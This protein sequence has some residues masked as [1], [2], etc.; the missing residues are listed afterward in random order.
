MNDLVA[1]LHTRRRATSRR[2][3]LALSW[4]ALIFFSSNP[5]IEL[6]SVEMRIKF[7]LGPGV[8]IPQY[9]RW[10]IANNLVAMRG[11]KRGTKTD[12]FYRAGP[13]LLEELGSEL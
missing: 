2:S 6:S 4:R 9:I 10:L 11:V 12:N 8:S 13:A 5:D 1:Q 7:E 3:R